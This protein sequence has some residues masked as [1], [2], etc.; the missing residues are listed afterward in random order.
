MGSRYGPRKRRSH[1]LHRLSDCQASSG[2]FSRQTPPAGAAVPGD[3]GGCPP[4][5][6]GV[7]HRPARAHRAVNRRNRL[8]AQAALA[9]IGWPNH[10]S[11]FNALAGRDP[12]RVL[13]D[14]DL[15]WGQGL[16]QLRQE[17]RARRIDRLNIAYSGFSNPCRLGLPPL[18]ALIPGQPTTGWIAVS[19]NHFRE[20][21]TLLLRRDPCDFASSLPR[22]AIPPRPFRWLEAHQPVAVVAGIRLYHLPAP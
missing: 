19:E 20:R 10:L 4:G 21:S 13:L 8:I 11:S 18:A 9:V 3:R 5:P 7:G 6:A 14:S 2:H 12:A 16:L 22:A 1:Q 15:D 17:A